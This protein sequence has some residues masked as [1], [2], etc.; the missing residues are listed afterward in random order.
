MFIKERQRERKRMDRIRRPIPIAPSDQRIPLDV[1]QPGM[2]CNGVCIS[3]TTFGAYID[4]GTECDGLLHVGQMYRVHDETAT[5]TSGS[6]VLHSN[7]F[8]HHPRQIVQPGD[9]ITVTIRSIHPGRKKLH[10]TL[11]PWDIVQQQ[12]DAEQVRK[13]TRSLQSDN[14]D[15][16]DDWDTVSSASNT[17]NN[18]NSN[19]AVYTDRITLDDLNVDD[20]L[21]GEIRRVTDFGAYVEVGAVVDG[22]LHFMDHPTFNALDTEYSNHPN[23]NQPPPPPRHP[24]TFMKYGDR[25]R[26]W[27][28]DI[29]RVRNRIKLTAHRP[30]HLP[31]PRR[32]L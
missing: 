16:D 4:I 32:E 18:D 28:A 6:S 2:R 25:I 8:V 30:S 19:T 13:A 27:V 1:F 14:D 23:R 15:D 12:L 9:E 10:F 7:N 26:V 24:T 29:D 22:F 5:T 3:L 31:G 20:E 11:L 21:W 17:R